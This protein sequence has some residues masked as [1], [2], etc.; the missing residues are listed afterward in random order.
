VFDSV[1]GLDRDDLV[2]R[3][4]TSGEITTDNVTYDV[5]TSDGDPFDPTTQSG[6]YVDLIDSGE[7][8]NLSAQVRGDYVFVNSL[9]PT[10]NPCDIGGGG[11]LM[12]FGLDGRTPDRTI[13]PKIGEPVVGYKVTGGVPNQTTFID[14]YSLTPLSNSDILPDEIDVGASST[15][16]G[17]RSWQE[18][19]D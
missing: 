2:V 13:W 17:R 6:W 1:G 14:D 5:R 4:L 8:I 3:T 18:L 10:T 12:A 15:E 19:Y 9:V 11:W 7:R 16:L